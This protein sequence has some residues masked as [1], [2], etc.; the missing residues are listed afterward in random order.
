M[1]NRSLTEAQVQSMALGR[2]AS[3]E[4]ELKR[5]E[6]VYRDVLNKQQTV[7]QSAGGSIPGT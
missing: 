7:S 2:Q 5:R 6:A 4:L 1:E 3:L